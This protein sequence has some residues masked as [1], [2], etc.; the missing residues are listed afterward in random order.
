MNYFEKCEEFR[1]KVIDNSNLLIIAFG[2][3]VVILFVII[4]INAIDIYLNPRL[5]SQ[6][7]TDFE[8]FSTTIT[9]YETVSPQIF[10]VLG[11]MISVGISL[12]VFPS[13]SIYKSWKVLQ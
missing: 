7:E 13:W 4:T 2:I 6:S 12:I 5:I 9:V 1:K 10:Y 8:F 3:F 11:L